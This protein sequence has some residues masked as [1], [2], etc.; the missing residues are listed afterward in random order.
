[1]TIDSRAQA[2]AEPEASAAFARLFHAL[3]D[4]NRLAILQHLATGEHR[5]RD[6]VEHMS[7]AQSTVSAHLSCLLGCGLVTVRSE[8]R[9]SWYALADHEDLS[10]LLLAAAHLLEATGAKVSLCEDLMRPAESI[11]A[12]EVQ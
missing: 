9:S 1:M 8:G 10:V 12:A 4:P 7:F 3:S 6:L 11:L 2:A 5:V